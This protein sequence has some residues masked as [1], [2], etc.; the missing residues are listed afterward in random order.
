MGRT[1]FSTV[2]E[3]DVISNSKL[4]HLYNHDFGGGRFFQVV[5]SNDVETHFKLAPRTLMKVVYYRDKDD[6][7]SIEIVKQVS[8]TEKES[9]LIVE[10]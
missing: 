7:D 9:I 1:D 3:D 8:D 10:S 6:I 2:T 5:F 4:E